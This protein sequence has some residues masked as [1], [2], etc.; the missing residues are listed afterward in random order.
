[1]TNAEIAAL[2]LSCHTILP[3]HKLL[4]P[5]EQFAAMAQWCAANEVSHD[6]YGEGELVQDFEKKIATLLGK[7]AALFCITGTLTQVT[8]LRLACAERGSNL[9]GL[10]P[11]SHILVHENSNHQLL[12][13]FHSCQLGNAHR[14]WTVEDL[15]AIPE[16]IGAVQYE[17]P[18]R[19]IG[20][21]LPTWAQLED[22]KAYCKQEQIHLHMDGA[23]LWEA[24]SYYA[25]PLHEIAG[26]FDTVYVSFYKGIG[27][28]GGAMLLGSQQMID[29]ARLWMR[30]QGGNVFRRTPYVVAAAMQFDQRIADMRALFQRTQSLYEVLTGYPQLRVNPAQPQANMLHLYLPVNKD[31][32]TEIRNDI[33]K[34]HGIW[35]FGNAVHTAL[36]DQSMFEWY[37]GDQLLHMPDERLR[38]ALDLFVAALSMAGL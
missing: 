7:E 12:Q 14:P 29:K 31:R 10:H 35:L 34:E 26:D 11:T 32:A 9:V 22:I 28:L 13:H 23:R 38:N 5:A 4:Q 2:R 33:A 8:A 17:L 21:Q 18:M 19:E 24:Q 25:R 20:G 36:P 15:K 37:V 1:M 27:G 3:G 16:K 6:T 30:R